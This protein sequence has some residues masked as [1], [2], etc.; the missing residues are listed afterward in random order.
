M[1]NGVD[2]EEFERYTFKNLFFN[3]IQKMKWDEIICKY[4]GVSYLIYNEIKVLEE[5]LKKIEVE[6]EKLKGCEEREGEFKER[7]EK[8][9]EEKLDLKRNFEV[10]EIL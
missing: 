2:K 10:K 3:E 6:L 8:F 5:K 9:E 1:E 7:I 4:C